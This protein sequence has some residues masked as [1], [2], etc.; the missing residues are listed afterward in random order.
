[1]SRD[2]FSFVFVLLGEGAPEE[3]ILE[4]IADHARDDETFLPRLA[5]HM[6]IYRENITDGAAILEDVAADDGAYARD[7]TF[8]R[9]VLPRLD[10]LIVKLIGLSR[11]KNL[12][13]LQAQGVA[14]I[15]TENLIKYLD[16]LRVL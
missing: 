9:E 12:T 6:Q 1:M 3:S 2:E 11:R 10:S 16:A 14:S 15:P 5:E 4:R 13:A 7:R 8:S